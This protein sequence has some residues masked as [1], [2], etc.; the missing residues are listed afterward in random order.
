MAQN[1]PWITR[2]FSL[3][4][5]LPKGGQK[6]QLYWLIAAFLLSL[7]SYHFLLYLTNRQDFLPVL[8]LFMVL[9]SVYLLLMR[10]E[11]EQILYWALGAAVLLRLSLLLAIPELSD[12][13][14]RFIWDGRLLSQGISPFTETPSKLMEDP[15]FSQLLINQQLYHGMNSRD[16][17]TIYPPIAQWIFVI[18]AK[19][20]PESIIGNLV[21]MRLFII[22]AELGSIMLIMRILKEHGLSANKV[23]VYA[24]NPLVVIELTGNLHFEAIMIF[25]LLLAIYC[26]QLNK[27]KWS[28]GALAA[29][30]A[31]KLI[32][33]IFLPLLIFRMPWK[34]VAGYWALCGIIVLAFFLTIW[35]PELAENMRSSLSLY[36][37]K[38]EFNASIYY[39]VRE[40]GFA[41]KGYNIIQEAGLYLALTTFLIILVFSWYSHVSMSWPKAMLWALM[42]YLLMSTTVHPWYITPLVALA[43]FT[44]Y[45]FPIVWSILVIISYSGYSETGFTENIYLVIAEYSFLVVTLILDLIREHHQLNKNTPNLV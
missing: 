6:Q 16:Y 26:F 41:V 24:W 33:L 21:V 37:Q 20:F 45:R 7:V 27:W 23:L 12:D 2:R 15:K 4:L 36:F 42:V 30:I 13:F 11:G 8:L 5:T 19:L 25:F 22:L 39:L 3:D 18:A 38:F 32:P 29:S 35:S 31:T 9:S 10:L 43:V 17:F 44:D 14:Y 40:I 28:A 1:I 34:K